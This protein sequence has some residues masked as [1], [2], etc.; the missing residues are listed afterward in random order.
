MEDKTLKIGSPVLCI[1]TTENITWLHEAFP[2]LERIHLRDALNRLAC[3]DSQEAP[4]AVLFVT[5]EV[6]ERFFKMLTAVVQLLKPLDIPFIVLNDHLDDELQRKVILTGADDCYIS[7]V[8]AKELV[9]RID[10]LTLFKKLLRE[11]APAEPVK[12]FDY[13]ISVS[14]RIF[15]ITVSSSALLL[16]SP[17][18]LFVAALIKLESKGPVFYISKRAGTGY[19]VFNFLK[20]RSMRVG[21]DAELAKLKHLNQYSEEAGGSIFFKIENDPR[22]TRLGKFLRNTS[23]DELPQ[24]INVLKGDMSIVGNRPL[25]LYEAQQLTKDQSAMRFMAASGI[26]GL[27]QVSKRGKKE[28]S[29]DERIALD[30]EYAKS[31]SFTKDMVLIMKTFPALSQDISV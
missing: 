19:K 7:E 22:I 11:S 16:L 8:Q 14:K 30:I 10:F 6:S 2:R 31:H 21:A 24:L 15:D 1:S 23:L 27:W 13:K 29:V 26:T 17:V 3:I 28:L 9:Y 12:Q 5:S 25:P 20:F 4:A 18:M